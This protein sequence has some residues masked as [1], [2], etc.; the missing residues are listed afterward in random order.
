MNDHISDMLAR[1]KNAFAVGKAE[2]VL[3]HTKICGEIA[4][5][6][7]ERKY[8]KE[9]R[10]EGDK[11][12]NLRLVL[13]YMGDKPALSQARRISKPGV[14]IYQKASSFKPVLSGL[15]LA[16]VSTSQGVMAS[17]EA[18]K[19]KLGGEVLMEVW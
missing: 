4:R 2:V 13:N 11:L 1:L 5:V 16:I 18:R 12:K 9:A 17:D 19:K 6:L 8:L 7:V 10:V 3:P 14:R 15:G